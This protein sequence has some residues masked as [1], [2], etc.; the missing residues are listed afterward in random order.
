MDAVEILS[1]D[2]TKYKKVILDKVIIAINENM[3]VIVMKDDF[4]DIAVEV[5]SN[6]DCIIRSFYNK[7]D[8]V[9][10]KDLDDG[11]LVIDRREERKE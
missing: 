4:A 9:R 5:F 11:Y 7:E 3:R 10:I 8:K 6:K 1:I 2:F